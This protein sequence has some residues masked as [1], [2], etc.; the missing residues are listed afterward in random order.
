MSCAPK[1]ARARRRELEVRPVPTH[2]IVLITLT[3][4]ALGVA[5]VAY[6]TLRAS[7]TEDPWALAKLKLSPL[8]IGLGVPKG[9]AAPEWIALDASHETDID[10]LQRF[11][12]FGSEGPQIRFD[13]APHSMT[14][15]A[16]PVCRGGTQV[17]TILQVRASNVQELKRFSLSIGGA[18]GRARARDR[19]SD[20]A[21]CVLVGFGD[22]LAS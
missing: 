9:G 8:H 15:G 17:L 12:A 1:E 20:S 16:L 4:I 2:H 21:L 14:L 19:R 10:I 13:A 11:M 6:P 3:M 5:G 22:P 7:Q 18:H